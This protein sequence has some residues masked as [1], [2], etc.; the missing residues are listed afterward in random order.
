MTDTLTYDVV[1]LGTGAAGL[2]AALS[3]SAHGASVGIFEK[4]PT[5]GGTTAVSG[6]VV[7]LPLHDKPD[8]HGPLTREDAVR[9][10]S[11]LS[12]GLMDDELISTFVDEGQP[13]VDFVEAN[14]PVRFDVADGFPDYYPEKPGGRPHGGRS[15][16]PRPFAFAELGAW[17]NKV[18]AFPVD[19]MTFG[20]DVETQQRLRLQTSE[21]VVEELAA[22]DGRFM[23]AG[24]IGGLL[25]ALLDRGITPHLDSPA[26]ELIV[27][28]GRVGGVLVEQ[29]GARIS[30]TARKGVVIATGGFEWNDHFVKT[31]LRGPMNGAVSPPFN[32]GDGLRM[33]MSAGA[34]LGTMGDAWWVPI[35]QVPDDEFLGRKRSRSIRLERTRPRSIM[36]NVRGERFANEAMNYN[37]LGTAFH[38][39]DLTEFAYRNIPAWLVIDDVH[40]RRY[41]FLGVP[42]GG[43]PLDWFNA[44]DSLDELAQRA[45][46]RLST[47]KSTVQ[48]WNTN[49]AEGRDPDFHRGESVHDGWWGD[50]AGETPAARTLGPIDTPPFYA[51]PVTVGALGTKG[52][53]R[54]DPNGKV[55][56]V[57]GHPIEGLYAAGNAMA[58]VTALAYGGAGGTIGPAMVFGF[59]A[60]RDAARTRTASRSEPA[61]QSTDRDPEE[62][63]RPAKTITKG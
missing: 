36:V 50:W 60:G 41:G 35:I 53:P 48:R 20:F 49:V 58:G 55:L 54:T 10:L 6:G 33:A 52:G 27:T 31:F 37:S 62:S 45:G 4:A 21:R 8:A 9:Y 42:P 38:E 19:S 3:A 44:S 63:G 14:S 28:D 51:V 1:V 18:T 56:H 34:D 30:V 59:L 17:A 16:N 5:V 24:L 22:V 47:L 11:S 61:A 15:L 7:W 46:I 43:E 29:H 12:L 39:F 57:D 25:R 13:M 40:L 23:G 2:T 26:D 32:T